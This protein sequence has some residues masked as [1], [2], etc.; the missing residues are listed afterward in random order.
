MV[1]DFSRGRLS[2]LLSEWGLVTEPFTFVLDRRGLV[3]AKFEGFVAA[4]EL[5]AALTRA[6][7]P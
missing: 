4:D 3:L 2:P 6:L 5:E 1:A 7:T